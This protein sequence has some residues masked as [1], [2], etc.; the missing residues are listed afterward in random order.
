M[1]STYKL[2]IDSNKNTTELSFKYSK[3]MKILEEFLLF[4][5]EVS[6]VELTSKLFFIET[7]DSLSILL[8]NTP[9]F[10]QLD[11]VDTDTDNSLEISLIE[12]IILTNLFYQ[13]RKS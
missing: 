3:G 5:L 4:A 13:N 8:G 1:D 10:I 12:S 9:D 6:L 7:I 2:T 11:I